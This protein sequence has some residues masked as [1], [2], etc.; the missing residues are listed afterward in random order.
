M[1]FFA[2][3]DIYRKAAKSV[4]LVAEYLY[5]NLRRVIRFFALP[6]CYY[7]VNWKLCKRSKLAVIGDFLYIFF[8]L[9]YY[10]DNYSPCRLWEVSKEKWKYYYGS[11][12]D[13]H[14][15]HKLRKSVQPKEYEIIFRDK[16]ITTALCDQFNINTPPIV[17]RISSGTVFLKGIE[18]INEKVP[19]Y[20]KL[21]LKPV[22]GKGGGG[23]F[24]AIVESGG[25]SL[26]NGRGEHLDHSEVAYQDLIC[27]PFIEQNSI[28]SRVSP[29][30]NTVRLVTL[31][32][33]RG[34]VLIIGAYM[35]FG[36]GISFIDN[37]SQGGISVSIDLN[38]GQL[39][40][41]GHDRYGHRYKYHPNSNV[42]FVTVTIPYWQ[43]VQKL[44]KRIQ[45]SFPFYGLLGMDIAIGKD[46]P[47]L[48]EINSN[49]DN[50]D[51]EQAIGP[52]LADPK[53][54]RAYKEFGLLI[55]KSQKNIEKS[56][57]FRRKL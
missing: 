18:G 17:G 55:S 13:P 1:K 32:T 19:E 43:S 22:S 44:A 26:C 52:I 14:Q 8:V 45:L 48:I 9:R 6:Y 36:T 27:Q 50:V 23:I 15:R 37:L 5:L 12:Y 20:S 2:A 24:V 40:G 7:N 16:Y 39:N 28:I 34:S 31:L 46:E 41:M 30:T 51:L 4:S 49:F 29:S 11:N 57:I 53:V 21:I 33:Q 47:V 38:S 54:Y 3:E 35:R 42:E 56:L 25:I 10:P